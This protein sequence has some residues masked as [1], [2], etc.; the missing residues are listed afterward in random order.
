MGSEPLLNREGTFVYRKEGTIQGFDFHS[1]N[2]TGDRRKMFITR[3]NV[4]S[5]LSSTDSDPFQA[6]SLGGKLLYDYGLRGVWLLLDEQ[7]R[8]LWVKFP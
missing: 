8:G 4:A 3:A 2:K 1:M 6:P 7:N 5:C